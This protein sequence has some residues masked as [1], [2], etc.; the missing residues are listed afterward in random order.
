MLASITRRGAHLSLFGMLG[1]ALGSVGLAADDSSPVTRP[2][3]HAIYVGSCQPGG[4][5]TI[6]AAVTGVAV[7]GIVYVC[8]GSY[9]EQVTINKSLT[10][11]GL[12]YGTGE[13]AV[14]LPPAGGMTQ[15]GVDIFGSPVEAQI[16]VLNTSAV[17]IKNMTVDGTG[18]NV[19]GCG[20]PTFEGIYFQNSSG[21]IEYDVV[22]NQ[23]QTDYADYGGCQNGLAVNVESLTAGPA[24][25]INNNSVR[26]YQKNGITA[27]GAATTAEAGPAV[28][29]T[30]NYIEGFAATAMNW[31]QSGAAENGIQFGFGATGSVTLNTVSDNVWGQDVFG[32]TGDAASG[33]LVYASND[34]SVT[35]NS[36]NSA[37]FGIVTVTDPNYGT[38]DSGTISSN[39]IA[40]TQLYDA[41][42]LCSSN[43]TVKSNT[44]YN[45]GQSGIHIDDSCGTGNGNAVSSN[46]INEACAGILLGTGTGNTTTPNTYF[47]VVNTTMSGDTC[48]SPTYGPVHGAQKAA[49]LRPSPYIPHRKQ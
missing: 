44:I 27:T 5:A 10:L 49:K 13:A 7:G 45:S 22:R 41:I 31:P 9:P 15:S 3:P 36:V 38:A 8:P 35:Q 18:N 14:V 40:G 20:A 29:I 23:Y 24:V 16:T 25:T 33:I 30:K 47:N 43:N 21:T 32:D 39:H 28:T 2:P 19:A 26:A 48:T 17:T 42:D 12:T 11:V 34:V 6:Q 1:F 37:Q 46:L 4:S